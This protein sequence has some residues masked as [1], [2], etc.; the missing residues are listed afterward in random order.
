MCKV[1]GILQSR[2]LSPSTIF[3]LR[4]SRRKHRMLHTKS[5]RKLGKVDLLYV[6][7]VL[8]TNKDW[9]RAEAWCCSLASRIRSRVHS[10]RIWIQLSYIALYTTLTLFYSL[11]QLPPVEHNMLEHV[12]WSSNNKARQSVGRKRKEDEEF[13]QFHQLV[14]YFI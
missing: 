3:R 10:L 13:T 4:F 9:G 12:F 8:A 6:C 5:K 11:I 14:K 7:V 2:T 1:Q